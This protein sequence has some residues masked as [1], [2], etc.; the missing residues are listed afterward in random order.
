MKNVCR[1]SRLA[2]AGRTRESVGR[3]GLTL[4]VVGFLATAAPTASATTILLAS[5]DA[6]APFV[7][8]RLVGIGFTVVQV[9]QNDLSAADVSDVDVIFTYLTD[10]SG[11]I[12]GPLLA[13]QEQFVQDFVSLGGGLVVQQPNYDTCSVRGCRSIDLFPAGFELS[14]PSPGTRVSD[15]VVL[16]E[17]GESHF[18]TNGLSGR[19]LSGVGDNILATGINWTVL[20]ASAEAP[21]NVVLA[22]GAFGLGRIAVDAGSFSPASQIPA[23][24][25]YVARLFEWSAGTP[26]PE[27]GTGFL[28]SAGL[29]GIATYRRRGLRVSD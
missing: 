24:D 25:T 1:F 11:T 23:S 12:G 16:T 7:R 20:S 15:T 8:D 19:E 5:N 14:I 27:P 10:D 2:S 28:L 22:V 9:T 18:I 29:V 17:I 4:L 21:E 13:G 3:L 26:V 6:S